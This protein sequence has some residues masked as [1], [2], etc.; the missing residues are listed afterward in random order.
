VLDDLRQNYRAIQ[1]VFDGDAPGLHVP[2]QGVER[3]KR[4][5]G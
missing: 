4:S 1:L 2:D 3:V 5:A